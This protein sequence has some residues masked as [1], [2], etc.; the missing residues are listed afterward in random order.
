MSV[1]KQLILD[2]LR[3]RRFFRLLGSFYASI[4]I[5][6]KIGRKYHFSLAHN[7]FFVF[8]GSSDIYTVASNFASK[9]NAYLDYGTWKVPASFAF[10]DSI[11]ILDVGANIG[12]ST[13]K[14]ALKFPG[15]KIIAL[16]P[17][18]RNFEL[19]TENTT[20]YQDISCFRYAIG[21]EDKVVSIGIE[22]PE[23]KEWQAKVSQSSVKY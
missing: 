11:T 4:P 2:T 18:L 20:N 21:S 23:S 6:N 14:L 3:W 10:P 17:L 15:A 22:S 8:T 9:Q 5:F 7:D 12:A 1:G 19:L 16:E 13:V